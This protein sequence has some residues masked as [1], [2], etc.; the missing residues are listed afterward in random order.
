MASTRRQQKVW[1][2]IAGEKGANRVRV[3]ARG[4]RGGIWVDYRD[5]QGKRHREPL[6]ELTPDQA[7]QRAEAIAA[8]FRREGP[9]Q[10]TRATLSAL[11]D[12]YEGEVT[13]TKVDTVQAHDRRAFELFRR[14]FGPDRRPETLSRRDWDSY[15]SARRSGRLRPPGTKRKGVRDRVI[16]QDLNLL[17]ALLNWATQ[18]GDGRGGYLLERNPLKGLPVPKEESPKR[19]LLT[20]EQ[21][22]KVRT[23]AAAMSSRLECFAVL[24]WYTGHRAASI[25][26]LRWSDVDLENARIHWRGEADKI[27]LD[28]WNPLHPEAVAALKAEQ[29]RAAAIGDAWVFP[30]ARDARTPLSRNAVCNLWKRIAAKAKL[31]TGERYGWHSCRRA[32]ANRLRRVPLRDLQDLGGWKTSAT[33]LTVYL[34][35]DE[36]AQREALAQ[37]APVSATGNG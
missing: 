27:G 9:R 32:F 25:R 12:M 33:L 36:D 14:A 5:D 17:N 30:A 22:A 37:D 8:K 3:Y 29:G 10:P 1:S 23:V 19:A 21:F 24:A 35:A 34:R 28:H 2:F 20:P 16:E 4:D 31:P 7:K 15:I 13:P 6:G 26:Q 11:I 18:A